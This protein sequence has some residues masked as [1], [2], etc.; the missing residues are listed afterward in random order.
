MKEMEKVAIEVFSHIKPKSE[1]LVDY[2]TL[3]DVLY[4]N[5]LNSDPQKADFGTRLGDYI[6]RMKENMVVGITVINAKEHFQRRFE[7]N[8]ILPGR[9]QAVV[10]A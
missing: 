9:P 8:P 1:I 3:A 5:F 6:V 7:D 2:D 10:S 4:I